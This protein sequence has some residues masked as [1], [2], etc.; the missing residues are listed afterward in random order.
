M[1]SRSFKIITK[2]YNLFYISALVL[3]GVAL[4]QRGSRRQRPRGGR[5]GSGY[6]APSDDGYAS[7]SEP[8]PSYDAGAQSQYQVNH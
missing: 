4:A 6:S 3:L 2:T 7:P 5:D 8:Q 1:F